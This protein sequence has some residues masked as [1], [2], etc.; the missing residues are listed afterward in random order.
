MTKAAETKTVKKT[1]AKKAV[2]KKPVAKKTVAKKVAAKKVAAKK[3]VA[4]KT[5]TP[6]AAPAPKTSP[7]Y[8]EFIR[9][10]SPGQ[11]VSIINLA[12]GAKHSTRVIDVNTKFITTRRQG[13]SDTTRFT[14]KGTGTAK[15]G[16]EGLKLVPYVLAPMVRAGGKRKFRPTVAKFQTP[17]A[18]E[19]NV[20]QLLAA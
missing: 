19:A 4:K 2:A 5:A 8:M 10:V 3:V 18:V 9:T 17:E 13:A 20:E 14:A 15:T 12:T 1:T 6:K 16:T 7:A 11:T